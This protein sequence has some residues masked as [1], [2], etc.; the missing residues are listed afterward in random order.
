MSF[1]DTI[2]YSGAAV[3]AWATDRRA[4][5]T[6]IFDR[7][8]EWDVLVVL[9]SCRAD[10]LRESLPMLPSGRFSTIRSVGSITTEWLSRTFTPEHTEHINETA[11]VSSTPHTRTV[12]HDRRITTQKKSPG[13][14][15][16]PT[17]K[18]VYPSAFDEFD[19]LWKTETDDSG[20]VPPRAVTDAAIN[21]YRSGAERMVVHYLQ[22]HEPFLAGPVKGDGVLERRENVWD[23]MKEGRVSHQDVWQSYRLTLE[24]VLAEVSLL[25]ENIDGRV[26]ITSDHGNAFGEFGVYGHPF[27][28]PLPSVRRVPWLSVMATD[29]NTYAPEKSKQDSVSS[30]SDVDEQLAAL[31]YR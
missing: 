24:T 12:F 31:G 23:A 25:L 10:I 30:S 5:G 18:S 3:G 13:P 26:V 4:V 6:N 19:E 20:C 16:F 8:D 29:E 22:P 7:A 11:L 17:S 21:H 9:D 14:L 28:C 2:Y 1:A 27:G 15:P